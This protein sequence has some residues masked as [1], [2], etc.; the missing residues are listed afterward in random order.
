MKILHTLIS[1][2]LHKINLFLFS[3]YQKN[4]K[5]I[6]NAIGKHFKT[7]LRSK[8]NQNLYYLQVRFFAWYP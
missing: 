1:R 8:K 6:S 5:Q 4:N 7:S 2:N 3:F